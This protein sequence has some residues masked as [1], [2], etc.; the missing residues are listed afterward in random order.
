MWHGKLAG[1][2]LQQQGM[3]FA[4]AAA[5]AASG[6]CRCGYGLFVCEGVWHVR[7][8]RRCTTFVHGV[9]VLQRRVCAK[10]SSAV[11]SCWREHL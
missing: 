1:R 2:H 11:A 3:L 5:A 6:A 10:K 4:A 9:S 7:R 8:V